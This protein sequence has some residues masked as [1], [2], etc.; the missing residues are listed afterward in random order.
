[1]GLFSCA[2]KSK[3]FPHSCSC[4][5][6]IGGKQDIN[7]LFLVFIHEVGYKPN[8]RGEWLTQQSRS[9]GQ[10]YQIS[11]LWH[12]YILSFSSSKC[13]PPKFKC[14]KYIGTYSVTSRRGG[15][16]VPAIWRSLPLSQSWIFW[17]FFF[18]ELA[19]NSYLIPYF[20]LIHFFTY[21]CLCWYILRKHK[22]EC[23]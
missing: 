17:T 4:W 16:C 13:T 23:L 2:Y 3:Y 14:S 12:R 22:L 21:P 9:V 10:V 19:A 15:Y 8:K 11:L 18:S 6:E 1:M 7:T 20:K 5:A